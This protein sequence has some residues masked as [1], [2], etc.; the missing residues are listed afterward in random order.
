[1]GRKEFYE[2]L[3]ELNEIRKNIIHESMFLKNQSPPSENLQCVDIELEN[4]KLLLQN[5]W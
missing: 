2:K 1:M 5:E 3:D 4:L